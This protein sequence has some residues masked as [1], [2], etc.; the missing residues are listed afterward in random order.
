[1][2]L[3]K[4]IE[5]TE[6]FG[7]KETC[8]IQVVNELSSLSDSFQRNIC[9]AIQFIEE[10]FPETA[11]SLLDDCE[12]QLSLMKEKYPK[13]NETEAAQGMYDYQRKKFSDLYD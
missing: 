12:K 7:K 1:M 8:P 5:L 3:E 10:G 13:T 11:R 6:F 2:V 4:I 9:F